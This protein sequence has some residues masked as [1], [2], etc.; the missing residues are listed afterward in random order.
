MWPPGVIWR[1]KG[2]LGIFSQDQREIT[3]LF[4]RIPFLLVTMTEW[5]WK[6]GGR[7]RPRAGSSIGRSLSGG[8][9]F[10]WAVA[11]KAEGKGFE[12][13]CGGEMAG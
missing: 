11:A 8:D 6:K 2:S 9:S 12:T 10:M 13:G 4:F 7:G 1:P 5:W 3:H